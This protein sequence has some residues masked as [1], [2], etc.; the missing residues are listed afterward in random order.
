MADRDDT[1]DAEKGEADGD[2]RGCHAVGRGAEEVDS[3]HETKDCVK[4]NA[5]N[6]SS[7]KFRLRVSQFVIMP[8]YQR[9]GHGEQLLRAVYAHARRYA[10]LS[11]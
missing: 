1:D 9:R 8:T 10:P 3:Q 11:Y 7:K 5:T 4:D 6:T 2:E